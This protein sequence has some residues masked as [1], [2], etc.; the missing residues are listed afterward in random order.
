MKVEYFLLYYYVLGCVVSIKHVIILLWLCGQSWRNIHFL[1]CP[2]LMQVDDI[3]FSASVT[4]KI[5]VFLS[6]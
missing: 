1:V 2:V 3:F 5:I 4:K 6:H